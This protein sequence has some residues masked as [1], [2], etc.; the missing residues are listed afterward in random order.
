VRIERGD[1]DHPGEP[2]AEWQTEYGTFDLALVETAG[3]FDE[4]F[5]SLPGWQVIRRTP[6]ATLYKRTGLTVK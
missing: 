3:G 6:T 4:A 5:S 1:Y 2:L